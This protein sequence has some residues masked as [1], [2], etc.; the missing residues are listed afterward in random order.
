MQDRINI[1]NHLKIVQLITGIAK[2]GLV[3]VLKERLPLTDYG[4]A[5]IGMRGRIYPL[6]DNR[7]RQLLFPDQSKYS[8]NLS[9]LDI[10]LLYIILRNINT[11]CPHKTG[12]GQKPKDDDRS[13]SANIDRIRFMKNKYVS[14]S[15]KCSLNERKFLKLWKNIGKC[16]SEL[17]DTEYKYEYE[18]KIARL[19]TTEMNP[20]L[21]NELITVHK[22]YMDSERQKQRM[23]D[24][25]EGT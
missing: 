23:I 2:D 1:H 22:T 3:V 9:D 24:M 18:Q 14:H 12:W 21:E 8:G 25:L 17:G 10:G 15:S 7:E 4:E 6:L 16:I 20:V 11:I 5:F 19:F 13:L